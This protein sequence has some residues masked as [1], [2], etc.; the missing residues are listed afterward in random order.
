MHPCPK[1]TAQRGDQGDAMTFDF[2]GAAE[3]DKALDLKDAQD[4]HTSARWEEI[5][6][7]A[8]TCADDIHEVLFD[9][10]EMLAEYI[11]KN[12][13]QAIGAIVIAAMDAYGS[14]LATRML[15]SPQAVNK[16]PNELQAAAKALATL[17]IR[18]A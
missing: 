12:D 13:P 5:R 4:D 11:A 18:R 14:R 6:R 10:R 8:M 15:G 16:L 17:S 2:N 7:E 3:T 1:K 9:V